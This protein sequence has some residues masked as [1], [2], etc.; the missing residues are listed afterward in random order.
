[1]SKLYYKLGEVTAQPNIPNVF[2]PSE[3]T[4]IKHGWLEA[5]ETPAPIITDRQI[6]SHTYQRQGNKWVQI[7]QVDELPLLTIDEV[8]QQRQQAYLT[9]SDPILLA[10]ASY[11]RRGKDI[12]DL[13]AQWLAK[14]EEIDKRYPYQF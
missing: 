8:R 14:I 12:T 1:M 9:E 2:F 13:E 3:E 7:W 10:I 5:I 11:E 6:A 4:I